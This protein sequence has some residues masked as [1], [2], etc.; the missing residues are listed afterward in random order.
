MQLAIKTN[1]IEWW[2]WAVTLGFILLALL[3]WIAGF[4]IVMSISFV[5]VL[6]FFYKEGGL[7]AFP[8]QVR[9]AYFVFTL[10]GLLPMLYASGSG[11]EIQQPLVAVIFGGLISS[12]VL[13]LFIL[14]GLYVLCNKD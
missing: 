13:T 6:Y 7:T 3:G 12:L 14:P 5:Q 4:Y 9:I 2:F 1:D 10:L 8:T 11:A